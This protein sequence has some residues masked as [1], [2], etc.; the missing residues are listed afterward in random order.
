MTDMF[1]AFTFLFA[2][3]NCLEF[4]ALWRNSPGFTTFDFK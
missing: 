2:S 4:A 3:T 1:I